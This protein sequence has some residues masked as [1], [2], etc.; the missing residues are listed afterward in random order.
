MNTKDCFERRL[1][2][3]TEPSPEKAARALEM[4]MGRIERAESLAVHGFFED[5]IVSA[6]T[7]MFQ[8]ARALLF[9]DGIV[10]KSHFCVVQYLDEIYSKKGHMEQKYVTWLNTYREERHISLYGLEPTGTEKDDSR[11]AIERAREFVSH[12]KKMLEE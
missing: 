1:L 6:Y 4:A 3:R 2:R 11:L 12:V 10:E 8:A 5:A 9:K 7:A